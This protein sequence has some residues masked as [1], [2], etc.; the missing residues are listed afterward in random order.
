MSR[1]PTSG[2]PTPSRTTQ[3]K[4]F[5]EASAMSS[6]QLRSLKLRNVETLSLKSMASSFDQ[7]FLYSFLHQSHGSPSGRRMCSQCTTA[8]RT[9]CSTGRP[10]HK[11]EKLSGYKWNIALPLLLRCTFSDLTQVGNRAEPV[12]QRPATQVPGQVPGYTHQGISCTKYS[13]RIFAK[14]F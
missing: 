6:L 7:S 12:A 3:S 8:R 9:G 11:V 4:S 5:L 10:G 1:S 13:K 2:G 14:V